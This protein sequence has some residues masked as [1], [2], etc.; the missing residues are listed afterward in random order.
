MLNT[1]NQYE[2]TIV[3]S[4]IFILFATTVWL[5]ADWPAPSQIASDILASNAAREV[6]R[7]Q[8]LLGLILA[9]G[10]LSLSYL[11][12]AGRARQI[13]RQ[14]V[15]E[16]ARAVA[17]ALALESH[18]LSDICNRHAIRVSALTKSTDLPD[19]EIFKLQESEQ[20]LV[21]RE[22]LTA[23]ELDDDTLRQ[24]G[25]N[26]HIAINHMRHS[27]RTLD[28]A[29]A[30]IATPPPES[31]PT[32]L[33]DLATAYARVAMTARSNH[34]LFDTLHRSGIATTQQRSEPQTITECAIAT[35]LDTLTNPHIPPTAPPVA[36]KAAE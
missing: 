5:A 34:H 11:S 32:Q 23:L 4:A 19:D 14:A 16:T 8:L 26:A 17:H 35:H 29:L 15:Q 6:E 9:A 31:L 27:F 12:N 1:R 10:C 22:G 2:T 13:S 25:T 7:F 20:I 21:L 18:Q 28:Q 33:D 30:A 3:C 24:L 36:A